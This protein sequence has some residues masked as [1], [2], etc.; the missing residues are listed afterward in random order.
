M[1]KVVSYIMALGMMFTAVPANAVYAAETTAIAVSAE[2][3]DNA[4]SIKELVG[5]WNYDIADDSA[6]CVDEKPIRNG[7]VVIKADGTYVH[8][9][10]NGKLTEGAV[11]TAIEEIG[12]TKLRTVNFYEGEEFR[13]GGYY[14]ED[15]HNRISLGNGGRARLLRDIDVRVDLNEMVGTWNYEVAAANARSVEEKAVANGIVVIKADGTYVYTDTN[16]K[17][18][19]GAVKASSLDYTNGQK[20]PTLNFYEG[21]EFKFGG[22]VE[23]SHN[24]IYIGNGGMARLVRDTADI[25]LA[26]DANCDSNVDLSDSVLIMQSI[27]NPSKYG[28]NGTDANRI[29]VQGQINADCFNKGDGVTNADALAVQRYKLA[30]IS[31]LSDNK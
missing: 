18:T 28:A 8:T 22:R 29:T 12:G 5:T 6:D 27:S 15:T 3:N 14:N 1:K 17:L 20:I 7:V 16:K 24:V 13:F 25:T 11:K 23:D 31:S 2:E 9:D 26:G 30:L 19:E 10:A 21:Q 4:V